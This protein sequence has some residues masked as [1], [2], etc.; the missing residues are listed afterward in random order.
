MARL[1]EIETPSSLRRWGHTAVITTRSAS[2]W[3]VLVF[4]GYGCNGR[5][6]DLIEVLVHTDERT[7]HVDVKDATRKLCPVELHMS[8]SLGPEHGEPWPCVRNMAVTA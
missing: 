1:A 7:L 2:S 6:D 4:G 3:R 5:L 8:A